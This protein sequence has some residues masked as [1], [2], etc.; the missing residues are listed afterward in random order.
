[1]YRASEFNAI[2]SDFHQ[3]E[4]LPYDLYYKS[5]APT[6][7]PPGVSLEW[8]EYYPSATDTL[9]VLLRGDNLENGVTFGRPPPVPVLKE[10]PNPDAT[11]GVLLLV[12]IGFLLVVIVTGDS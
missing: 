11:V 3:K 7:L 10:T 9:T 6:S 2:I 12:A 8:I 1:M 5:F 4:A